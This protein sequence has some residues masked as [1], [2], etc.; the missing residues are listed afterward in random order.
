MVTGRRGNQLTINYQL[1]PK[2]GK[3]PHIKTGTFT[4]PGTILY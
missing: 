2:L 3:S 4:L 1:S